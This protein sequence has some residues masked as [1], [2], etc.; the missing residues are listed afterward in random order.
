MSAKDDEF[1]KLF[2]YM[3][4]FRE[5]VKDQFQENRN[6]HQEIMSTIDALAN[7]YDTHD[8]EIVALNS[9]TSRHEEQIE[10]IARAID[11]DLTALEA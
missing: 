10:G 7:H 2:K 5:E 6:E 8:K 9:Q 3:Q 4:E 1:T 11:L